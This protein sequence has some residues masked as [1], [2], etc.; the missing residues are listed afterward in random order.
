MKDPLHKEE[1]PYDIL[2]VGLNASP[3]EITAAFAKA[4]K[5]GI[6]QK[7]TDARKNLLDTNKRIFIDIFY[8]CVG[9]LTEE[10]DSQI[11]P[12][13]EIDDFLKIPETEIYEDF[14]D[15]KENDISK[16]F[17]EIKFREFKISELSKYDDIEN[18]Q[19]EIPFVKK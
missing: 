10:S 18:I 11:D 13:L 5:K 9:G 17:K 15:L 1:T 6:A 3:K 19:L 16:D 2:E 12:L 14:T 8:Y 7:A 4:L